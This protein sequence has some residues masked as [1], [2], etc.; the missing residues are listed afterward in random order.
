MEEFVTDIKT[1]GTGHLQRD[2]R[3]KGIAQQ[4][5]ICKTIDTSKDDL[6]IKKRRLDNKNLIKR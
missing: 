1:H 4:K 5:L 3:L 2:N 6:S